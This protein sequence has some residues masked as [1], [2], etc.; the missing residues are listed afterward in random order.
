MRVAVE[1]PDTIEKRLRLPVLASI[2]HSKAEHALGTRRR[3]RPGEMLK[4]GL[5]ALAQPDDEA[6]EA[7]RSLR[8]TLHFAMLDARHRSVL[9]TGPSQDIG[10][11]FISKNLAAVLAQSGQRVVL[12]DADLRKGHIHK[13]FGVERDVGVSEYV[14]GGHSLEAV[15]R[16]TGLENLSLVTTGRLPPHPSELLMHPR[17]VALL[18]ALEERFDLLVIDAPP[19]LAV[20]DAA[21]VGRHAGTTLVVA[22]A[23]RHPVRELEQT[24]KRMAQAGIAVSGIVFNDLDLNRQRYRYGQAGY[25]YRYSYHKA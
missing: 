10:K 25:V 11:S 22:R 16:A 18:Q 5:L 21:I 13:E 15:V 2:P 9:I 4:P 17:F 1:D 24:V 23:G 19:V 7:L 20:A 6:V 3:P 14:A 12:V 8:A